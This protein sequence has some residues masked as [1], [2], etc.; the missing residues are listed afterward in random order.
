[1]SR[2]PSPPRCHSSLHSLSLSCHS[3]YFTL[4]SLPY[5][6]TLYY[7]IPSPHTPSLLTCSSDPHHRARPHLILPIRARRSL[8]RP[9]KQPQP[10]PPLRLKTHLTSSHLISSH[11]T[12]TAVGG[13]VFLSHT[14][15]L[16]T[17]RSSPGSGLCLGF[18]RNK[19]CSLATARVQL[20]RTNNYIVGFGAVASLRVDSHSLFVHPDRAARFLSLPSTITSFEP[21]ANPARSQTLHIFGHSP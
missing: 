10:L 8:A 12:C 13:V 11:L 3:P 17:L 6:P 21:Y 18:Q 14:R 19:G 4:P 7:T 2:P 5:L 9:L 15:H 1:V 20:Q 16:A